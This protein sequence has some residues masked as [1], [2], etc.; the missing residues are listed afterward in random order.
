MIKRIA[1]SR[2]ASQNQLIKGR[3]RNYLRP[4]ICLKSGVVTLYNL[5]RLEFKAQNSQRGNR[6]LTSRAPRTIRSQHG[7]QI[8]RFFFSL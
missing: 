2:Q 1:P 6:G 7:H 3:A 5:K 4:R 8:A